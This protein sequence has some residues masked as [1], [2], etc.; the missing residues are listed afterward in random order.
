MTPLL[1]AKEAR[2]DSDDRSTNKRLMIVDS[3]GSAE[4]LGYSL[5]AA[6]TGFTAADVVIGSSASV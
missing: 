5:R 1:R 6:E 4:V 3:T 2:N